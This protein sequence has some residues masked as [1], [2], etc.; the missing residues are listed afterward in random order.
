MVFDGDASA[1]T[2]GGFDTGWYA[3][4]GYLVVMTDGHEVAPPID[5][6][7]PSEQQARDRVA[8]LAAG[9]ASVVTSDW[10]PLP[11]VLGTVLPRG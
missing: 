9:G 3:R 10:Y 4:N 11:A 1:F 5:A 6:V 2:G 7:R 8:A